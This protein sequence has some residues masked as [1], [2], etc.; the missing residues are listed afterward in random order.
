MATGWMKLHLRGEASWDVETA[1][2]RGDSTVPSVAEET[3]SVATTGPAVGSKAAASM[4][5]SHP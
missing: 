1:V 3:P 5:G 2:S 4:S